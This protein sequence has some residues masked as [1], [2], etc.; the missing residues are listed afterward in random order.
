MTMC[1]TTNEL[2]VTEL[3]T[4]ALPPNATGGTSPAEVAGAAVPRRRV[5]AG[6]AGLPVLALL[7]GATSALG[8]VAA[9]TAGVV[10]SALHVHASFSEGNSGLK[11]LASKTTLASMESQVATLAALGVDLC[12]FTDHDHRMGGH[13]VGM[14]I[15]PYPGT[16]DMTRPHWTYVPDRTASA[17]AGSAAMTTRGLEASVTAGAA[18]AW[19]GMFVD[20]F[21]TDR[22]YR[23]T[24]A[25]MSLTFTLVHLS[26]GGW[27]EVR[28]RASYHPARGG[29]PAG[30]YEVQYRFSPT[31]KAR[32]VVAQGLAAVVTIPVVAN[33]TQRPVV[34]PVADLR[35]AFPDFGN[36]ASD[37]GLYGVWI[38]AGAPAGG[39]AKTLVTTM[40]ISRALDGAGA[41]DLQHSLFPDLKALYPGVALGPGLEASYSTHL[42]MFSPT[43]SGVTH[44]PPQPGETK[45]AY[46]TRLVRTIHAAGGVGSFNHPFGATIGTPLTGTARADRLAAVAKPLLAN[47]LYG[48]EV[49]EVGYELRGSMDVTGHLDL[50]DI[51]LSAGI[52]VMADGVSD[53][54]AGTLTSWT[55]GTNHYFT[56]I[57]S[58]SSDP[59]QVTPLLGRGRAF[60]SLRTGFTGMLDLLCDSTRMGGTR[61]GVGTSADITIIANGVPSNGKVRLQQ[62]RIHGDT[63]R[64]TPPPRQT[65]VAIDATALGTGQVTVRIPNVLSYVRAEVLNSTGTKVA[66]S[67][68]LWLTP[69]V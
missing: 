14:T 65:D 51:L 22:D 52:R 67:N 43:T 12:F 69:A 2:D 66:F 63:T 16:E 45:T 47:R 9:S 48:C 37:N 21:P 4:A 18:S 42:N 60:V 38:G 8:A 32:S 19:R 28:L 36:L 39:T 53:D 23:T 56:D 57:I 61:T 44:Q 31:A 7:P 11:N 59:A 55:G 49:L 10:R 27:T 41:L 64:L 13:N 35:A 40:Q 50:W 24:L 58:T 25:G 1:S 54:H 6:L 15:K 34:T 30:N 68:P 17:T 29:R 26:A 46:F 33:Q 3:E 5:L 20:C 62:I